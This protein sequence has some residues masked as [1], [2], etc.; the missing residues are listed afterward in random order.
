MFAP[1]GAFTRDGGCAMSASYD[2]IATQRIVKGYG[3]DD[4][5]LVETLRFKDV[6]EMLEAFFPGHQVALTLDAEQY[7]EDLL[8]GAA[9]RASLARRLEC[10]GVSCGLSDALWAVQDAR[11]RAQA[12]CASAGA[13]SQDPSGT[14]CTAEVGPD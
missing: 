3:L 2:I 9:S 11:R 12:A 14:L 4:P 13:S 10:R 1:C 7:L 8:N 6:R 5:E